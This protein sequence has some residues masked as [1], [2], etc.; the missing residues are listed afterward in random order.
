MRVHKTLLTLT[1]CRECMR[2]FEEGSQGLSRCSADSQFGI[3]Q[4]TRIE[5]RQHAH[6]PGQNTAGS[7]MVSALL[8]HE[9]SKGRPNCTHYTSTCR[10]LSETASLYLP[11]P[12]HA[13]LTPD[14]R[15]NMRYLAYLLRRCIAQHLLHTEQ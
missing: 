3:K 2:P 7:S 10:C 14:V 9:V 6:A 11:R 4:A 8:G 13:K 15:L 1:P 5:V 12:V